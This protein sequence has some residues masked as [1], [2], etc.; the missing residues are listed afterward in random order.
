[1]NNPVYL[2][3]FEAK[4]IIRRE[5]PKFQPI[6][7][8]PSIKRDISILIDEVIPL[9]EIMSSVKNDATKALFKLELFDVYQGEGIEKE[10]KSI[11]LGLTFQV[12]SS[13]LKDKEVETI[14]GNVMDG[15]YNKFGAKLRE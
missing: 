9:E 14:M 12:T 10:K 2:F 8:F 6:S 15:L 7:R 4:N 1:M 11:A 3:D 5:A 13:T